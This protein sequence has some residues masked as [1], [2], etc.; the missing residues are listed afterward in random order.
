MLTQVRTVYTFSEE[1]PVAPDNCQYPGRASRCMCS[2]HFVCHSLLLWLRTSVMQRTF[3]VACCWQAQSGVLCFLQEVY[4]SVNWHWCT[5]VE[6]VHYLHQDVDLLLIHI[7]YCYSMLVHCFWH[8]QFLATVHVR[9]EMNPS[10]VS[11]SHDNHWHIFV[12]SG[13][14]IFWYGHICAGA[15]I[16]HMYTHCGLVLLTSIVHKQGHAWLAVVIGTS[17]LTY[18][19]T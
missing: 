7:C 13:V 3:F 15:S 5:R 17:T 11:T 19:K 16:T 1:V 18:Q 2:F 12:L 6:P 14:Q 9:N 8:V 4:H 10:N